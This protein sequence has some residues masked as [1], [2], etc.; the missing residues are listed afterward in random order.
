MKGGKS[1]KIRKMLIAGNKQ[2]LD[3]LV[4]RYGEGVLEGTFKSNYRKAKKIYKDLQA[5]RPL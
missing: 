2:L 3:A 4:K 1:K 5:G